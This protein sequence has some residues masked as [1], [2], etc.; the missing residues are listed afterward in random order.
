MK[1]RL[2]RLEFKAY[3]VVVIAG[4]MSLGLFFLG[5]YTAR[6]NRSVSARKAPA[7]SIAVLPFDNLSSDKENAYF[8]DGIQDEILARLSK[9]SDLKV[10][11][12]TSTQHY[13]STRKICDEI[14]RELG[15]AHILEGSVQKSGDFGAGKRAVNRSRE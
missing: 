13:K 3:L 5:R 11:S 6:T 9:V 8:V 10:I 7:K 1:C 15:V 14:G 12:R 4:A 2:I